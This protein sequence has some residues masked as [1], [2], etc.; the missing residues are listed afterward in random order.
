MELKHYI[1]ILWRRKWVIVLTVLVA[2]VASAI[3]SYYF[4]VP[5]Y[6]TSATIWVPTTDLSNTTSTGDI[7]LADRLINTYVVLAGSDP[8]LRET[9]RGS[10]ARRG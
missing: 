8:V 6:R 1:T 10:G 3:V 5:M 4:M 2:T 9:K 7:Q